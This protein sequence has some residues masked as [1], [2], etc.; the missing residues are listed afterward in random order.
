[1]VI[2]PLVVAGRVE[3]PERRRIGGKEAHF[4]ANEFDLTKLFAAQASIAL[5]NAETHRALE[6]R[7]E[8]D[9]LTGLRNHGAFQR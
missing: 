7:A 2:V 3:H 4:S 8:L 6:T 9:S 5:Q 1:M